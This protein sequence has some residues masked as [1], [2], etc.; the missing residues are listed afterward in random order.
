MDITDTPAP[1]LLTPQFDAAIQ[2]I[3][4]QRGGVYGHPADDFRRA[5]ALKAVVAE[6]P[7]P[8]VR[9]AL[10]M[11]CVK[12]ARLINAPDHL[13]SFIDIAGYARTGVMCLDRGRSN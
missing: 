5:T 1:E 3:T 4:Q 6:C 2:T 9:H 7:N 8:L 12:M 11:I 13:D 10:E